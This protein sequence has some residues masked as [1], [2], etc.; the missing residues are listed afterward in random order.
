MSPY[1]AGYSD[2]LKDE[3]KCAYWGS[4]EA[5]WDYDD[6][7]ADGV[8][9]RQKQSNDDDHGACSRVEPARQG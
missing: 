6:G 1:K 4:D 9:E 3:G 5:Q 8:A 2:G 7:Y